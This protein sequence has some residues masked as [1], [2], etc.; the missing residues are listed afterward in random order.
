MQGQPSS[1]LST[2]SS[3]PAFIWD[4][5][6]SPDGYFHTVFITLEGVI[7]FNGRIS[8]DFS[9]CIEL[10]FKLNHRLIFFLVVSLSTFINL[11]VLISIMVDREKLP[12]SD[13]LLKSE[14]L[15]GFSRRQIFWPPLTT[16]YI[17][18]VAKLFGLY[19]DTQVV[20]VCLKAWSLPLIS[21]K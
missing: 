6:L 8:I 9:I 5:I 10:T 11:S 7:I 14:E 2:C 4:Q 21:Y 20:S 16:V 13:Y 3:S 19:R 12:W 15:H 1:P 18:F 17:R